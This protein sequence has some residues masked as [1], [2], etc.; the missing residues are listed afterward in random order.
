MLGSIARGV[1]AIFLGFLAAAVI[2]VAVEVV[3]A[4]LYPFPEG[5]DPTDIEVCR[6]HIAQLPASAFLIGVVGWGLAV[7]ASSWVATRLAAG[8]HPGVRHRARPDPARG[9]RHEYGHAAV[10][11]LVLGR[12][13]DR[14][15]DLHLSGSLA[16]ARPVFT[17]DRPA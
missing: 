14:L 3:G 7:F 4:V 11:R 5:V 8:R 1:A 13:P 10:S 6:A 15:S 9:G 12:E 16:W 17:Q 2:I